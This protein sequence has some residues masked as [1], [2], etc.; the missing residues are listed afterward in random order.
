MVLKQK[1]IIF[2]KFNA[3]YLTQRAVNHLPRLTV[4]NRIVQLAYRAPPLLTEDDRWSKTQLARLVSLTI[5]KNRESNIFYHYQMYT[6][7]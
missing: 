2:E 6:Y 4:Q 5:K 3:G 7:L 1:I